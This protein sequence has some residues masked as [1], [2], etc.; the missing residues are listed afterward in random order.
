M[1]L[2]GLCYYNLGIKKLLGSVNDKK[3]TLIQMTCRVIILNHPESFR[4][5]NA[6]QNQEICTLIFPILIRSGLLLHKVPILT[7]EYP[8][9]LNS[10]I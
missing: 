2:R 9:V 5:Y 1:G 6:L 8:F 7:Y 10:H 4:A 3:I